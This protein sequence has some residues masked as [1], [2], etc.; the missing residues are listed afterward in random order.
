MVDYNKLKKQI[1]EDDT[2]ALAIEYM[3]SKA[4]KEGMS[5]CIKFIYKR[6]KIIRDKNGFYSIYRLEDGL[7]LYSKIKWQDVAKYIIDNINDWVKIRDIINL[8]NEILR[9]KDK[10]DFM[11]DLYYHSSKKAIIESKISMA[12]SL[13]NSNKRE[14]FRIIGKNKIC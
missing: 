11:Q 7:K 12:Y 14:L 13:Y 5:H 9:V 6:H 4:I 2:T 3:F 1:I 8:Q 10:I